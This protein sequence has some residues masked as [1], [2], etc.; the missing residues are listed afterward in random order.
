DNNFNLIRLM[1]ALAVIVTHS[2][3]V[4]GL[5][6]DRGFAFDNL[7]RWLGDVAID[8][9]FVTSGFLVTGSL[10]NRGSL[11]AFLWARALRIYPALWV[12]LAL[13]VLVLAPALTSL[14]LPEYFSAPKT[15]E[16]FSKC[17]T[18]IGGVR[19]SLPGLFEATPLK[20]EFNGSLWTLPVELRLYLTLAAGWLVF[21]AAPRIRVRALT[22]LAPLVSALF[23][24]IIVRGRVFGGP[25]NPADIRVFMFFYGATLWLWRDRVPLRP[26]TLA[27]TLACLVLAAFDRSIFFV[28]LALFLCPRVLHLAYLSNG[29]FLDLTH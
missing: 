18:L 4:L 24:I 15:Y 22:L 3:P 1:A 6:P 27:A 8:V 25:F 7:G 2:F 21:A 14:T 9:F 23:L 20:G 29:L 26:S 28:A 19:W 11:I 12:M 10:F 13:T 17:A 16:Y 5:P